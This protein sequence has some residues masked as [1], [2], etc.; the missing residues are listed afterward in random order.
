VVSALPDLSSNRSLLLA[1]RDHGYRGD[2]AI[3]AR[4]PEDRAALDSLGVSTVLVPVTDAVDRAID[5]LT[6][7]MQQARTPT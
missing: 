7:T 1:L 6:L 2:V 5:T 3:V 4:E